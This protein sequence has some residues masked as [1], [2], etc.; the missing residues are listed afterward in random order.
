[1]LLFSLE[2]LD[3]YSSKDDINLVEGPYSVG[4]REL[5]N[6]KFI[7]RL[8][9]QVNRKIDDIP[10]KMANMVARYRDDLT[11]SLFIHVRRKKICGYIA[12]DEVLKREQKSKDNA[13]D[14][15][16]DKT[17]VKAKDMA[18]RKRKGKGK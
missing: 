11:I 15:A 2:Y 1:M 4:K 7:K 12:N 13:N 5:L 18:K 10:S 9:S 14:K 16:R 8:S 6:Y 17:K 3:V